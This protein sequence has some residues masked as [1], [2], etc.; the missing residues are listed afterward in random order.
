MPFQVTYLPRHLL[1]PSSLTLAISSMRSA[2]EDGDGIPSI[3]E[4]LLGLN[5][6]SMDDTHHAQAQ[7]INGLPTLTLSY[8][9]DTSAKK[10]GSIEVNASTDLETWPPLPP[11]QIIISVMVLIGHS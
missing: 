2:D 9:P 7:T 1:T 11:H 10:L 3:G 5:P 8:T 6:L 4:Y